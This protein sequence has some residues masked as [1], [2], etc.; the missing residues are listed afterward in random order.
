MG[1]WVGGGGIYLPVKIFRCVKFNFENILFLNVFSYQGELFF[2]NWWYQRGNSRV[3]RSK[4]DLKTDTFWQVDIL[5]LTIFGPPPLPFK[6]SNDQAR[7]C[8]IIIW[9]ATS[10]YLIP[11]ID[12]LLWGPQRPT[13]RERSEPS[14]I[15]SL[16]YCLR[17]QSV[18]LDFAQGVHLKNKNLNSRVSQSFRATAWQRNSPCKCPNSHIGW[19]GIVQNLQYSWRKKPTKSVDF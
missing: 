6:P 5:N 17:K 19:K 8:L 15:G 18:N 2:K 13:K 10:K 1:W 14:Y 16:V 12:A 11:I 3:R 9:S 7:G 4:M